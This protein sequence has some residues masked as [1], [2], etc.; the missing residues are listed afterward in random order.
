MK[1]LERFGA[2]LSGFTREDFVTPST[3]IQL[4]VT[5]RRIDILTEITGVTF[6]E[7]APSRVTVTVEGIDVP[8]ISRSLLLKNTRAAGLHR[9]KL[10]SPA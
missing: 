10:M 8:V 2:P 3:V 1:A 4:G 5:P 6:E 9:T 7:A